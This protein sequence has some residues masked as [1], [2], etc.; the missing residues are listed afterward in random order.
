MK[1]SAMIILEWVGVVISWLV[2]WFKASDK[3]DVRKLGYYVACFLNVYWG[4]YFF[5]QGQYGFV[6]N[7]VVNMLIVARGIRNNTRRRRR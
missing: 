2:K 7:A 5:K 1:G 3:M 6:T 4:Y